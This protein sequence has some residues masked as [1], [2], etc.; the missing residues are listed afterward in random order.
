MDC[1]LQDRPEEIPR[2]YAK[3]Q[4]GFD[5]VLALRGKRRDAPLKRLTSWLFYKMFSY[6]ADFD[7][8]GD[9]GNFRIVSRKVVDNLCQMREQLRFFGALVH[10]MGFTT[11]GIPVEHSER[12][13]GQSTYT[14]SKLWG[15][16]METII[17]YSDKP[18]RLAV[19]LGFSMAFLSFIYGAYLLATT[20]L[21]GAVVPGWTSLMVSLFFIGGVII[22]IQG[23]VGI[24]IGKTFDETKK[25]P[26]YIVGRK[27]F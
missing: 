23:V 24:Y 10:W 9:S 7:Y 12:L 6:L 3:A 5:I 1:D 2:L 19:K 18:L 16:A 8:D 4:E 22:S 25:R 13:H 11:A 15:L 17:A 26:L 20:L 21:H 27:T 14:F